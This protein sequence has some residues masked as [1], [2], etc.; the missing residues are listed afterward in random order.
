MM[1]KSLSFYYC[2][3]QNLIPERA[4]SQTESN[5]RNRIILLGIKKIFFKR[6]TL[7]PEGACVSYYFPTKNTS[8]GAGTLFFRNYNKLI[9][10]FDFLTVFP[11]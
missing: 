2:C 7:K 3:L 1:V 8:K 5:H 4:F 9:V 11:G 10:L 6:Y